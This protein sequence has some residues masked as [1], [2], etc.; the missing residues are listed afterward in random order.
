MLKA[1]GKSI[2]ELIGKRIKVKGKIQL[3]KNS[4]GQQGPF[5]FNRLVL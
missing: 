5:H 1:L 3:D 2:A 4:T